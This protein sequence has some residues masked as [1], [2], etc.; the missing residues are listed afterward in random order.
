MPRPTRR[1]GATSV[2]TENPKPQVE[3]SL[4]FEV[5]VDSEAVAA[6]QRQR[7]EG[8]E[9]IHATIGRIRED[10]ASYLQKLP[11][12]IAQ[13][14]RGV[15]RQ[16]D[17]APAT[18]VGVV[19]LPPVYE[20]DEHVTAVAWPTPRS[21]TDAQ[22]AFRLR[23]PPAP[24]PRNGLRLRVTGAGD[25]LELSVRSIDLM[26]G[27]L[28]HV[29]LPRRMPPLPRSILAQL[30]DLVPTSAGE[31]ADQPSDF[32][33]P[34]PSVMLGEGDCARAFRSHS[35]VIDS[36]RYSFLFR[37]VPPQVLPKTPVELLGDGRH[38][39]PVNRMNRL[40]R[41]KAG[42]DK[43]PAKVRFVDRIPVAEPIDLTE[44][45]TGIET[46]PISIPKGATLSL[47]YVVRMHQVWVP[48]GLSLGDLLYSLPL[49]PGE[50]QRLAV[51][52]RTESLV[53]RD[54]ETM[55]ID[56]AQSFR[57][58]ADQSTAAL[59]Q[60]AYD[61]Q[62]SGGSSMKSSGSSWGIGGAAGIGGMVNGFLAGIGIAGG[63]GSSSS[64]GST[65]TWQ[66]GSRDFVSSASEQFHSTLQRQAAASRNAS[67]VAV[68]MATAS[69]RE[70][71]TTKYVA[72]HNR[73]H[74]LTVQY[75]QVLRHFSVTSTVDDV[76]LV[77]FVPLEVIA[78]LPPGHP[79]EIP[80]V[81]SRASLLARYG[82][83][84][85]H[86]DVLRRAAGPAPDLQ[87]GFRVM[88]MLAAQPDI[89]VQ[90]AQSATQS[91]FEL[92]LTGTFL[93][94]EEVT[95][96]VVFRS[97]VRLG[98]VKLSPGTPTPP[99]PPDLP[100]KAALL[101][102]LRARRE[103]DTG[104]VRRGT[105]IL[106]DPAL[107]T[108]V[109][110]FE[111]RR[112][113]R[114]LSYRT[115]FPFPISGL[116]ALDLLN[117]HHAAEVNLSPAELEAE[118]GSP[119]VWDARARLDGTDEALGLYSGRG[120][121][122]RLPAMLPLPARRVPPVLSWADVLQME[123]AF[124]HLVRNT[125]DYSR[126]VW[127]SLSPEERAI[128]LERYTIGV[129]AGGVTDASQ[130]VP[131]L[132]CVA[133]QVLG[134]F[135]N[136][137][138]MPFHIPPALAEATKITTRDVQEALL[139]FHRLAFAPPQDSIT[140]PTRG[141]LGEAVLGSCTSCEKVDITRFWNWQ[142]SQ[143]EAAADIQPTAIQGQSLVGSG[144]ASVPSTLGPA[145]SN[146]I[147]S[148]STGQNAAG[149][150]PD[151]LASLMKNL[152]SQ[153]SIG[154]MTGLAAL[155]QAVQANL[156]EASKARAESM[157]NAKAMAET[158]INKFPDVLEKTEKAR[159]ETR[160]AAE[161]AA[162]DE[163]KAGADQAAEGQTRM[164][165]DAASFIATAGAQPDDASAADFAKGLVG[166]L[167]GA[168]GVP[169]AS[170]SAL[171]SL[172]QVTGGDDA[173]TTRGKKALLAALGL[174]TP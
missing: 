142:D 26:D 169:L 46:D 49:A 15:L 63:Y 95:A 20:P 112:A 35:G 136:A 99:I 104:E 80:Q 145:P 22:G 53:V 133:N 168:A 29:R 82:T 151:L 149:P 61:E 113:F 94:T 105:V 152:P 121:A 52:E 147:L 108:D 31:V 27:N 153:S 83:A 101:A 30:A 166:E 72:N 5:P 4:D 48:A 51:Y 36:F 118:L 37:L 11:H 114:P 6:L 162:A 146:N 100:S 24:L 93:P 102:E 159:L 140:V 67:R 97:G 109:V 8:L 66:Q 144:G 141:M 18:L 130:E 126:A 125:V 174:P 19:A 106:P 40:F 161:K 172:F 58:Q 69:D 34:P 127:T 14:L 171:F 148:I 107:R 59:F 76:Q 7:R 16:P 143:M 28:G 90:G 33:A 25:A 116:G 131:L 65:S 68:R 138:V 124:Q 88:Q 12:R 157:N 70:Q 84:L 9:A 64:S 119:L 54:T 3:R 160:Q 77:C 42:A 78:F 96:T 111:F 89:R 32:A 41:G 38:R 165:A 91:G 86:L 156:A 62:A 155:A 21:V 13:E 10:L 85:R 74:A 139:R 2:A 98:P 117:L 170:A 132:D 134:F 43:L 55:S 81:V 87:H 123:A 39:L 45:R 57:E 1:A 135:G 120:A 50:S 56:E 150:T 137:M 92:S 23:L 129:P 163:K 158:V 79:R 17:G 103:A 128:L 75:W 60:S 44:F 173:A 164:K 154:D 71:V 73:C 47:G 167:F 110:R 115:R 122:V